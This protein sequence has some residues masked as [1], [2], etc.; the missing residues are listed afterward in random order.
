M[1]QAAITLVSL[2]LLLVAAVN[3]AAADPLSKP[4]LITPAH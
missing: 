2:L 3:T 1:R 4:A